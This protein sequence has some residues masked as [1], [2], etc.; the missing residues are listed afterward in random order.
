MMS[1]A[2]RPRMALA[3][4]ASVAMLALMSAPALA[5]DAT[6]QGY[7]KQGGVV[8]GQV[9]SG[10]DDNDNAPGGGGNERAERPVRSGSDDSLPFTGLQLG[11]MIGAGA[12]LMLLGVGMRRM[13]RQPS[14]G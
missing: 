7:S 2:L 5:A 6:T 14:A 10:Q 9:E 4:L 11:L 3:V 8:Q 1:R 13:A 12:G